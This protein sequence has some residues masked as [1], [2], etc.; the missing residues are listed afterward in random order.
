MVTIE[1]D[2]EVYNYLKSLGEPF[3]DTP[4]SVLRRIIFQDTQAEQPVISTNCSYSTTKTPSE[5]STP[6]SSMFMSQ[7]LQK[8]YD[9]KFH[10]LT[11][12]RTMFASETFLIYFQNF[13]KAKTINLWYRI[14]ARALTTLR[15][16]TK[17][18]LICFT[19]PAANVVYEIPVIDI[20]EQIA[21]ANWEKEFLEVN[22]DPVNSRWR[23]LDWNIEQYLIKY[24]Q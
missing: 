14:S 9:E 10:I 17:K 1:I 23:E 21:K 19:N 5:N 2:E 22:I 15:N 13:N 16:T 20:D 6:S 8:H 3:I 7:H 18:A 11:P 12:Y 4:N 24:N